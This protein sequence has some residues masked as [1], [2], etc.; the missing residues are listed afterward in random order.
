MSKIDSSSSAM[1]FS[2]NARQ[3]EQHWMQVFHK[4]QL[5]GLLLLSLRDRHLKIPYCFVEQDH[6]SGILSLLE[7]YMIKQSVDMLTTYQSK[8]CQYWEDRNSLFYHQRRFVRH[9]LISKTLSGELSLP[10]D[11]QDGDGDCAFT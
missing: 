11:I 7:Q 9:Y 1:L 4:D 6:L 3:F 10:I 8:I 2:V 5:V